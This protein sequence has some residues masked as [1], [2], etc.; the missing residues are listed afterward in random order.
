MLKRLAIL[1]R[2]H[3]L[4][5]CVVAVTTGVLI[6][7]IVPGDHVHVGSLNRNSAWHLECEKLREATDDM[8]RAVDPRERH[9][10]NMALSRI[11]T[12]VYEHG[13]PMP[14]LARAIVF[15]SDASGSVNREHSTPLIRFKTE[16]GVPPYRSISWSNYDHWPF[17]IDG[18]LILP[19]ALVGDLLVASLILAI[20]SGITQ[21]RVRRNGGIFRFH[22]ADLLAGLTVLGLSLGFYTYHENL[23]RLETL[24]E[25]PPYHAA[26]VQHDGQ[27]YAIR[28]Y[29]GPVWM[30]KLVGDKHLLP[31]L[32]HVEK[33]TLTTGPNWREAYQQLPK[34]VYL[35]ELDIRRRLPLEG[36][37]S[38]ERCRRLEDLALPYLDKDPPSPSDPLFQV[39]HL[40]RV[41]WLNLKSVTLRGNEIGAEQ[42]EQILQMPTI[43]RIIL[44]GVAAPANVIDQLKA[45]YPEVEFRV[46]PDSRLF[47][48]PYESAPVRM[49]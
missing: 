30:R 7:I 36:F 9:A 11:H 49:R 14:Y 31:F 24:N 21:W 43:D 6:L 39:E 2:V 32:Y 4:T 48:P 29:Q 3:W 15:K 28:K 13:W 42:I 45:K 8:A 35:K 22:L 25:K 44:D 1:R 18:W 23:Q 34:F 38:I 12:E 16:S 41:T 5:W 27:L 47:L 40:S 26:F 37:D 33:A 19:L 46:I 20:V 10:A 17:A